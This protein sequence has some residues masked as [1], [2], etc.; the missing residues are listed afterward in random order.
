M[1][2]VV[3]CLAVLAGLL[4]LP[5]LA[6]AQASISG[7]VRDTSGAV[8]PGVTV[9]AASPVLIEKVRTAVTDNNGRYQMID[10]RPGAYTVTFTLAGFNTSKRE[11]VTLSGSAASV[12]D[13]ELRVGALEETITVTGEAPTVDVST[14]SR[15]AVLSADT[16]DA[17][18]SSRNYA[19]LARMIP[20]AVFNGTDVG[21]SGLQGVGGSVQIHGSRQQ[22]QRV[23]LNGINTMTLQ[24]GG[25]IGGQIPDAGS[26]TEVTVDHTAVSAE[27][28]TGGVRINF[29]PRDGGNRFAQATFFTFTNGSLAGSNF[30]PELKAAG[31]T[32]PNEVK[33]NWDLNASFGGPIKRDKLWFWFSS[34]YIGTESWAPVARNLNEYK[35]A[36]FLYRPSTERGLLAGRSYNSSLRATWQA[37]PKV[38]V[39]GTYKQDKWCDCPNGISA[40]V[41]P[42]AARDFRFPV[43]RQIHG[44]LTS[45]ITN[46][47][48]VEAVGLHLYERWGFM[49][50]QAPRGSSP[51]FEAVAPQMISVTEQSNGLVY[52]APA[53]NNNNTKVPN[54]SYRAAM[55]YVTG[56]HSFKTGFNRTHGYQKQTNYNLNPLAFTVN[57]VGGVTTPNLITMRAN[58]VTI[59]NDLNND[60]GVFAQDKWTLK[61]TTINLALRFDHFRASFPE[62]TVGPTT[63]APTRNF[64]FPAQENL[65]W[66]DLTYRT[67]LIYDIRGNGKT[68]VKVTFNKYLRGQTLNLLGTDPNPV[69]TMVTSATRAWTDLDRD[70]VPDC[71]LLNF[72]VNGECLGINNPLFGSATRSA[73]FDDILRRGY[74]NRETNWEFSGGVQHEIMPRVS[75]DVGYFRRIWK[76]FRVTDNLAEAAS[77]YDTFSMTVP[78]D[79]RLPG[80]GGNRLE[81]LVALNPS[82]FGRP[83]QN[84]NTLDRTYGSQQEHWN[85][86]DVTL[87]ARLQNG[88]SL[89]VGTSTGKTM[90]NDCDIVAKV[91]EMLNVSGATGFSSVIVPAGT[92]NGWRPKAFCQ[93]ETPWLTQF[94]AFGVYIV[95]KVDVQVSGTFRSI[96]GDALRAVFNASNAYLAANSTL[97]RALAGGAANYAVDL[98]A[99]Y[100]VF[101]DRRNELDM[102]FGKVLR[103][104]RTKSIVSIDVYNFLNTDVAVNANQNFAVWLRPTA[105]LNARQVKFSVQFDY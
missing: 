17:L 53:L 91:P 34:R 59:N 105:I 18:P 97:G 14:T 23:T 80:G 39:A 1:Y 64:V 96:P 100:S 49:H 42:E 87:D 40:V 29:I 2:R 43:L 3:R 72:A 86:F 89:Q 4:V 25:N 54:F 102:R 83:A 41:A 78:S 15:S 21:G 61:R 55:A 5:S 51:E 16:I 24:A 68:A 7:V 66:N 13:G 101:L 58:E 92:P 62:Q 93:R 50:T 103:A 52:R 27:L 28:P 94:K 38:K 6:L 26:A 48:L 37:A 104:G 20:A 30:T 12:V 56:S 35:P 67:G 74:G 71:D 81:G 79:P 73:T 95:P 33:K 45:P 60:L 31:L 69:N 32:T 82:A 11:D 77:D 9:E 90:E 75:L 63:L 19:S 46:K 99:P 76:N 65:N 47:L 88:L 84:N 70:F 98:V 10:L 85:G 44:E 22:D 57:T 36:E 8:L